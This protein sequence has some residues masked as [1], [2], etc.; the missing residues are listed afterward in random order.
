M[1]LFQIITFQVVIKMNGNGLAPS[2]DHC[3]GSNT[4]K[5]LVTLCTICH[6]DW[7]RIEIPEWQTEHFFTWLRT[8]DR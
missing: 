2:N 5:N 1:G 4:E 3:K 6:D 7:H 8:N